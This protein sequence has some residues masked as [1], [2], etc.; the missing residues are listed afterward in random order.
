MMNRRDFIRTTGCLAT[1]LAF[2]RLLAE[3]K[4]LENVSGKILVPVF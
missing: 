1:T 4:V 3:E 2:R